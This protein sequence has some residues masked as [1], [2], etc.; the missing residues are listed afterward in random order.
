[1]SFRD[2]VPWNWNRHR[3]PVRRDEAGP[4]SIHGL[5]QRINE[6]FENFWNDPGGLMTWSDGTTFN[7]AVDVTEKDDELL[8]KAEI[9]GLG[10]EDLDIGLDDHVLTLRGEKRFEDEGERDGYTYRET[11]SGSFARQIP[12]PH[13]VDP[14]DVR[15]EVHDGVLTIRLAKTESE[16]ARRIEVKAA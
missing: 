6:L 9:P 5:H 10:P 16:K 13:T 1:M 4:P 3:V 15:A 12:L 8:V 7:P 2:L 14:D 11:R